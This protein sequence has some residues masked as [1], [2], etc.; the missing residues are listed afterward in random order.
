[1]VDCCAMALPSSNTPAVNIV[2]N[3]IK[4]FLMNLLSHWRRNS[5]NRAAN[6]RFHS[7]INSRVRVSWHHLSNHFALIA[8]IFLLLAVVAGC[9]ISP[10]RTVIESPSPTPTPS[11]TATPTPGITPT[12]TPGAFPT[13][14]PM[15]AAVSRT[16][17][18]PQFLFAASTDASL[19]SG[20]KTSSDGFLTPVPGSPFVTS[21]PARG[22]VP[23]QNDLIVATDNTITA[24][25]VDK[26][27]GSLR[28]IDLLEVDG[29][30][31]LEQAS[32][33]T[34]LLLS[35]QAGPKALQL[36]NGRLQL[37]PASAEEAARASLGQ[38]PIRNGMPPAIFDLENP[39][40]YLADTET[41]ELRVFLRPEPSG[42]MT[43]LP[44]AYPL[45]RGRA[46]LT[47]IKP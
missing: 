22:I 18:S 16:D 32:S 34:V 30:S 27:S 19:V 26:E 21:A 23:L 44:D 14:T 11:P 39:F 28:K 45:P 36:A 1:V 43:L 31:S 33:A 20:F 25:A 9:V 5:A 35:T 7:G 8:M 10:R 46:F 41:S 24:F 42:R 2:G 37:R 40:M 17:V 29:I 3:T 15:A 6:S 47:L 4:G 38:K 12:P 13:P